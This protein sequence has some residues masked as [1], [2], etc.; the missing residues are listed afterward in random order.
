[1][2]AAVNGRGR[3]IPLDDQ[4]ANYSAY[5]RG[6]GVRE[7]TTGPLSLY[8]S[9]VPSARLN[10]V[11]HNA[12][13]SEAIIHAVRVRMGDL[14]YLW[15]VSELS[16]PGTPGLL[17][18]HGATH[19]GRTAVMAMDLA[20]LGRIDPPA[21][22]TVAE[23]VSPDSIPQWV[24]GY[25]ASMGIP[26][27]AE[28]AVARAER[29]RA[30][31]DHHFARFAGLV[32]GEIVATAE[33]LSAGDLAGIYLVSTAKAFR[34]RGFASTLT[35]HA[36]QVARD[37]GARGATLQASGMGRPVYEALG[38]ETVSMIDAYVL[39]PRSPAA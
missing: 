3:H 7:S 22:L 2:G 28:N 18:A 35:G 29:L 31:P 20:G 37:R 1:M 27:N 24:H 32:D 16:H 23:I 10:A 26:A 17:E 12:D 38:F 4:L 13:I 14:P 11:T 39:P 19:V 34:G 25:S 9:G 30:Y 6:W 33:V 21:G 8:R 5:W 36:L 15:E